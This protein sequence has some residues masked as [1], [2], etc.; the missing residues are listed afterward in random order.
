[1]YSCFRL[2]YSN[3][4]ILT[5][6]STHLRESIMTLLATE[7]AMKDLE[8]LSNFLGISVQRHSGGLF[9]SR[10]TYAEDILERAGMSSC[11]PVATPVDINS[12]LSS[13]LGDPFDDST[14]YKSLARALQYLAFTRPDISY[15]VQQVCLHMHAPTSDDI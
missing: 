10:K 14:H 3:N 2:P 12:K 13:T 1:M 7:F 6:S 8:P 15:D 4:I 11:N 5:A 9:L